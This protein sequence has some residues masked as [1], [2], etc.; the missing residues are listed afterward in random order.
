MV[1]Y[2]I[3][4]EVVTFDRKG[5]QRKQRP[6]SMH[7]SVFLTKEKAERHLPHGIHQTHGYTTFFVKEID[8]D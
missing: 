1:L 5:P 6:A 7:P 4:K 3:W 8:V 2:Q